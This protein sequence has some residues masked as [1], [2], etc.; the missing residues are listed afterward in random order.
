MKKLKKKIARALALFFLPPIGAFLIW[1][2]YRL[3]KKEFHIDRSVSDKPT[4]FAVWHGDLLM[5]PYLYFQYR[6]KPHAKVLISDHF[7]GLIIS[8]T[9]RYFG[10]E[11]IAGSSNRKAV[12]ALMQAIKALKEGYDIGITPDGPKGPRHTVSDGI[13][14]MAQ[15]AKADIVLVEIKPTKYWQFNSWDRF[16]VP[17]PFGVLQYYA[18]RVDVTN[19]DLK[20]AREMIRKG[21]LE[22]EG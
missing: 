8:K 1:A 7:D 19:M 13:I 16:K 22:H 11:T 17:K 9:I 12:K 20:E 2:L 5:L 18:K 15:K 6:K 10:F 14:M 4:I 3:N 21:L